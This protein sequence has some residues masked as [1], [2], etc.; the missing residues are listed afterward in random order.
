MKK[1]MESD[2]LDFYG[3]IRNIN[4][5]KELKYIAWKQEGDEVHPMQTKLF[6]RFEDVEGTVFD[7]MIHPISNDELIQTV[8]NEEETILNVSLSHFGIVPEGHWIGVNTD[9]QDMVNL[10]RDKAQYE[11]KRFINEDIFT[12]AEEN[13][14]VRDG[15]YYFPV[16]VW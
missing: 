10:C 13:N 11:G 5:M 9:L 3:N 8:R 2:I 7:L 4:S 14:M 12:W 15:Y 1:Y 6:V 16:Y